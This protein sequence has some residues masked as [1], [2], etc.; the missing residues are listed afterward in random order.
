MLAL[1][2]L[3]WVL[4]V[5]CWHSPNRSVCKAAH[6]VQHHALAL[7]RALVRSPSRLA[8]ALQ[9]IRACRAVGGRITARRKKPNTY[10][11]LL[12]PPDGVLS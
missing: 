2:V 12:A 4:L 9:V 1:V 6:T 5:S 3:H 8:E 11:L 7:A 10:Q